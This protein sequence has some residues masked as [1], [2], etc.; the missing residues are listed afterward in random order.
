MCVRRPTC[1]LLVYTYGSALARARACA[2][3]RL[4]VCVCRFVGVWVLI[5]DLKVRHK[6][7]EIT[8]F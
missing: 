1:G 2:F 7:H 6:L 3:V 4:S 8:V 5:I